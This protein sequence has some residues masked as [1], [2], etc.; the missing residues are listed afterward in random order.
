LR[1]LN[2]PLAGRS[3]PDDLVGGLWEGVSVG[4]RP[5]EPLNRSLAK[6]M[7]RRMTNAEFRLWNRLRRNA[8][9]GLRFRRQFPI[10]R[11]IADFVC[12]ERRLIVEVDGD[13]HG[14]HGSIIADRDRT[15]WLES[16]GFRVLRF[17]NLDVVHSIDAVCDA[18]FAEAQLPPP[19]TGEP[20]S[21]SPQGGG[22][23]SF[24]SDPV[25][26]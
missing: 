3:K 19:E 9:D 15:A 25:N 4:H 24:R 16:N 2:L 10:G 23:G 12:L 11:Y 21:T 18:I 13:Q 8:I 6:V 7:R 17:G 5:I 1:S 26:S 14:H 20:V 22:S